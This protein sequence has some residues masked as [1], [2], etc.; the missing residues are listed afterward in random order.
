MEE[1]RGAVSLRWA[2]LW[3]GSLR[4]GGQVWLLG[5]RRDVV[6]TFDARVQP[7]NAAGFLGE[8]AIER[9]P[10][11]GLHE[12]GELPDRGESVLAPGFEL[13]ARLL[14]AVVGARPSL[15]ALDDRGAR[16]PER[17]QGGGE[18]DDHRADLDR[19]RHLQPEAAHSHSSAI[20]FP[21][22]LR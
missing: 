11:A 15:L 6:T 12:I 21:I 13:V 3:R 22:P 19:Q 16:V 9:R 2:S 7:S 18:Q 5:A 10:I 1:T 17:P 4:E 20:D 14:Q 8:P